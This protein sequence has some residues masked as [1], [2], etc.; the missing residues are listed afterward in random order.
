MDAVLLSS[1]VEGD[2]FALELGAGFG[3]VSLMVKS[4]LRNLKI[5]ALDLLEDYLK[6]LQEG[7]KLNGFQ[8][9][10][11]VAGD[12][13]RP[14][15]RKKFDLVF[16]NPPYLDPKKFRIS[17]RRDVAISKWEVLGSLKEFLKTAFTYLKE[18]G[19]AFFVVGEG[20]RDFKEK[21]LKAGFNLEETVEV[22]EDEGV[23]FRL[24]R[25]KKG[26]ASG[27]KSVFLMKSKG[28]YT[29]EMEEILRGTPLRPYLR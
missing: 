8:G 2:G 24:F 23:K 25:L 28:K 14:P 19:E 17:P 27:K 21:A 3:P 1:Y 15:L 12:V 5:L 4:R 9:I 26:K 29:P 22:L 16:S 10:F 6:L 20:A 11:P 18:E 7:I 13:R